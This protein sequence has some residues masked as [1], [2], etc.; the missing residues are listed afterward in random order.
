MPDV[1]SETKPDYVHY[2]EVFRRAASQQDLDDYNNAVSGADVGRIQRHGMRV[3]I[4]PITGERKGSA[5]QRAAQTLDWL[6]ANDLIY[7]H[8]YETAA[9]QVN[10]TLDRAG[11]ILDRLLDE[12]A[13][14]MDA[15]AKTLENAATL[16]DGRKVFLDK[17][18][19]V[20]DADGNAID[21]E[22]AAGIVWKGNEPS[23]EDIAALK[24]RAESLDAAINDVR[25]IEAELGGLQGELSD[26]DA[27][28]TLERVE[29]IEKRGRELSDRL[30]KIEAQNYGISKQAVAEIQEQ[31]PAPVDTSNVPLPTKLN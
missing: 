22:L 21:A 27:P 7:A 31:I 3:E 17:N 20:R 16:P 14:V 12:R 19:V 13:D 1:H 8:A 24:K 18:G 2:S 30:E 6:L 5:A 15:L 23:Y 11:D 25:G 4:D 29:D 10:A 28:A 9:R 26:N